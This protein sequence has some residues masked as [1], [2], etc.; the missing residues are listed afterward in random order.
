MLRI[1]RPRGVALAAVLG[2]LSV[3]AVVAA[4]L[5]GCGDSPPG[6]IQC[7]ESLS[8]ST[9]SVAAG[10]TA[11]FT[12]AVANPDDDDAT[13][14]VVVWTLSGG[15]T[16]DQAE[17]TLTLI[18]QTDPYGNPLGTNGTTTNTFN[19]LG[20]AGAYT[21]QASVLAGG[22]CLAQTLP[23]ASIQVT[24]TLPVDAGAPDGAADGDTDGAVDGAA[25][26]AADAAGD[27]AADGE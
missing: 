7:L 15:G 21:L 8:P 2:A 13:A 10:S 6:P 17:T 23:A 25:D 11:T 26:G 18:D 24:G 14:V 16:L 3:T 5:P 9:A 22:G 1:R 27:D 20:P 4:S 12:V 19:A